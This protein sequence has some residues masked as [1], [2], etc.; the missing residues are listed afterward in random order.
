MEVAI[1]L[2]VLVILALACGAWSGIT[3]LIESLQERFSRSRRSHPIEATSGETPESGPSLTWTEVKG[4]ILRRPGFRPVRRR[5]LV[6]RDVSRMSEGD[7]CFA[8]VDLICHGVSL[9]T[10]GY[11]EGCFRRR[12]GKYKRISGFGI[13][14]LIIQIERLVK[15]E[16]NATVDSYFG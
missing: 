7:A 12:N 2:V 6:L 16:W 1:L 10:F 5:K 14:D 13:T 15:K 4:D 9:I 8:E 3:S 11:F